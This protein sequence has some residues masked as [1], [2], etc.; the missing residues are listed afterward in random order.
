LIRDSRDPLHLSENSRS[1]SRRGIK[2][3]MC[4]M[5]VANSNFFFSR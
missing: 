2:N 1:S 3:L 5:N 4:S